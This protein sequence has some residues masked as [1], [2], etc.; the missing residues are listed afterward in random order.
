MSGNSDSGRQTG[1]P[2]SYNL[3]AADKRSMNVGFQG[4]GKHACPPGTGVVCEGWVFFGM[5]E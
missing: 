4:Q 2:N 1:G 3:V 5:G